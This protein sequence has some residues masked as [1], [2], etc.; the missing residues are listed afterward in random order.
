M[1]QLRQIGGESDLENQAFAYIDK[2]YPD[3]C[4]TISQ[5]GDLDRILFKS[6]FSEWWIAKNT[7]QAFHW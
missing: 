2:A 7:I 1:P 4:C 6:A 5:L 3:C